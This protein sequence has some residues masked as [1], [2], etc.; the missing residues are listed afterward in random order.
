ML[1]GLGVVLTN[2]PSPPPSTQPHGPQPQVPQ[3]QQH[4]WVRLLANL[5]LHTY[6]EGSHVY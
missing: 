5:V 3:R 2:A 1:R 4:E 6:S